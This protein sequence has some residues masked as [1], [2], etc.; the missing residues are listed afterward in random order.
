MALAVNNSL[1]TLMKMH[2]F[3]TEPYRVPM[4]GKLDSCLFDKTGTLTTDE[5]VSTK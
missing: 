4:A 3:C 2:I 5:L 1:M